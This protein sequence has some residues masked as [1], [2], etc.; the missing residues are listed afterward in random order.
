MLAALTN[1]IR[2]QTRQPR[3]AGSHDA[4]DADTA[5]D[6]PDVAGKHF[7]LAYVQRPRAEAAE[8]RNRARSLEGELSKARAKLEEHDRAAQDAAIR[9]AIGDRLA[10]PTTC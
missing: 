4:P 8:H 6:K 3:G 10:T 5:A 7:S 2:P 1:P 9:E